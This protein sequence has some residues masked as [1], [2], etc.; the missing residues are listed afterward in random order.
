MFQLGL[1]VIVDVCSGLLAPVHQ[2]EVPFELIRE[3][4]QFLVMTLSLMVKLVHLV[5]EYI[6]DDLTCYP[7]C[8]IPH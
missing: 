3:H 6:V 7:Y 4:L 8:K 2:H 5:V 1:V